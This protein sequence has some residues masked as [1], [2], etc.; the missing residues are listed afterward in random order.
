MVNFLYKLSKIYTEFFFLIKLSKIFINWKMKVEYSEENF[1]SSIY[2]KK[3]T[4]LGV[5]C[6]TC[7]SLAEHKIKPV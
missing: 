4:H 2:K 3:K 6:W 1:S 5:S 7:A